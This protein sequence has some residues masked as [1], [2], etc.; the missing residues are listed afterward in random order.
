MTRANLAVC[1]APTLLRAPRESVAA[2]LDLK[3][4]NVLVETLLDHY[5]QI[6]LE[7]PSPSPAQNG[8]GEREKPCEIRMRG[9]CARECAPARAHLPRR[10]TLGP[11][12]QHQALRSFYSDEGELPPPTSF[13]LSLEA[14]ALR[15]PWSVAQVAGATCAPP[16]P[17][18]LAARANH[19]AA[20]RINTGAPPPP[21]QA[22][23][24]P[25]PLP[26]ALL[27][28]A[29]CVSVST[30]HN[31]FS[32]LQQF[33]SH[34]FALRGPVQQQLG[35]VC[36][37]VQRV[38]PPVGAL[39]PPGGAPPAPAPAAAPA[40]LHAR[41]YTHP[42]RRVRTL[43]ACLGESEGELSFEPNQI[44]TNVAASAEP[45]WLRGTLNG[46]SGLVPEN[47][48]EPLPYRNIPAFLRLEYL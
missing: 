10:L 28:R 15:W 40:P 36:V 45:G 39:P 35:G 3:F 44:I 24:S 1:V 11:E 30:F 34:N 41:L 12:V 27:T 31:K 47:Y 23:P 20:R 32:N 42:Y 29:D 21:P 37:V 19:S 8:L 18:H 6:L 16:P 4:Y 26:S 2:I 14:L 22:S 17:R 43:Y 5:D 7:P 48:V 38:P 13:D 9:S 33:C 25:A 46:K